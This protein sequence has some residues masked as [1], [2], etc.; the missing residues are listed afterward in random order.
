MAMKKLLKPQIALEVSDFKKL[1]LESTVFV[2]KSL[3]IKDFLTDPGKTVLTTFPRKF[4]K[5]INMDM[6]KKFLSLEVNAYGEQLPEK[7]R[8]N[9]KLFLGGEIKLE[10]GSKKL[11]DELKIAKHKDILECQGRFPVISV[12]FKDT[13]GYSYN[14]ILSKVKTAL[15]KS[16]LEHKYLSKSSKLNEPERKYFCKFTDSLEQKT[17]HDHE[18]TKGLKTLSSLLSTHFGCDSYLLMDEYDV[19][20]NHSYIDK[21]KD[22]ESENVMKLFRDINEMTLKDNTCLEKG[23]IT[24]VYGITDCF[25]NNDLQYSMLDTRYFE[26]Y[27]FTQEEVEYLLNRYEVPENLARDIKYR[28]NGYKL[29]SSG[30]HSYNPFSIVKC[31]NNFEEYKN[32]QM[33]A[34]TLKTAI[35]KNYWVDSGN[36]DFLNDLLRVPV[37]KSKIDRLVRD[38]SVYFDIDKQ[39]WSDD[40][41]ALKKLIDLGSNY[42]MEETVTHII[43]SY[44]FH[45]GYLTDFLR[46][47]RF[48]IPNNEI[49]TV[50]ENKLLK[51]YKQEYR[52]DTCFFTDFTGQLKKIIECDDQSLFFYISHYYF[53]DSIRESFRSLLKELLKFEKAFDNNTDFRDDLLSYHCT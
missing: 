8:E 7:D 2:D 29:D 46:E 52:I 3:L 13:K 47:K 17:L 50:Y 4:G 30:K 12:D 20:I 27:G 35:L 40:L 23:L 28:Y 1:I 38:E 15:R 14:E 6:I 18:V 53:L 11:L 21:F 49:K 45:A 10:D 37:V 22:K 48:K 41:I 33:D 39:I 34:H 26:H 42:Q 16:F 24:G 25:P 9:R 44:L 32:T 5:S 19:A 51:F 43:Y 31:L 36:I